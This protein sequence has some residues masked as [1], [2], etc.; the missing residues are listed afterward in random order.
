MQIGFIGLGHMG[1]AMARR[2]LAAG[3]QVTVHNRTRQK[4]EALVQ[5]GAKLAERPGDAARGEVVITM[6]AND[7]AV[8]AAVFEPDGVLAALARDAIHL[9]MSTISV[10]LSDRLAEAHAQHQQSYVAAPV[11]GRPDVA[12]QGRLFILAAGPD[13]SVAR[14]EPLFAAMAQRHFVVDAMPSRANLVKLSANFLIA[15]MI[16]SLG[17]AVALVRK[18]GIDPHLYIDILTSSLFAAPIYKTYGGLIADEKFDPAGFKLALGLKDIR[19]ALAAADS[20]AVPMPLAS[21]VH[22]HFLAGMAQ[23]KQDLDWSALAQIAAQNAGL[24]R[25]SPA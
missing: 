15:S 24:T 5:D 8:E 6:L 18:A 12:E 21:L 14:C 9:S 2:L 23:G 3:H 17:E 16:E 4:A 25:R 22:D 19:L 11:L 20:H 7:E 13:K 10:A 1:Q